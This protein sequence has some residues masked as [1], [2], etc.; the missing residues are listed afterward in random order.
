MKFVYHLFQAQRK[1]LRLSWS[2]TCLFIV[3][4]NALAEPNEPSL[5]LDLK[6][7]GEKN[8]KGEDNNRRNSPCLLSVG[9]AKRDF[10]SRW[11]QDF[12][13]EALDKN[14]PYSKRI[15]RYGGDFLRTPDEGSSK[16]NLIY[17]L[18][19]EDYLLEFYSPVG[20]AGHISQFIF[21]TTSGFTGGP[22]VLINCKKLRLE[23]TPKIE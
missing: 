22:R 20:K 11:I 4:F 10:A 21:Y 9:K 16:K 23:E 14:K 7:I 3:G 17:S 15:R 13:V 12:S 6:L 8:Y 2:F 1:H 18:R 19:F 5:A